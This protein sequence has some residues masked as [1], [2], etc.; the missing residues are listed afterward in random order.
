MG[1]AQT[2]FVVE[3]CDG[4]TGSHETGSHV[5]GRDPDRTRKYVLRMPGFSPTFFSSYYSSSTKCSPVVEVPWLPE[6]TLLD[7]FRGSLWCAHAQ[8]EMPPLGAR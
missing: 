1:T 7:P 8:P 6:V 2:T 3:R 4:A 5:T